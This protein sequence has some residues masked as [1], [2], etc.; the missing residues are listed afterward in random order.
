MTG[1]GQKLRVLVA[2]DSEHFRRAL[3]SALDG[4]CEICGEAANGAE[5]VE[6]V[7]AL[8]PDLVFLDVFMPQMRGGAAAIEIRRFSP[9]TLIV[10]VSI[11]D[12][13][14]VA[15]LVRTCGADGFVNKASGASAFRNMLAVMSHRS[16]A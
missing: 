2:D 14:S 13:P 7:R 11:E 8:A 4:Y 6:K 1:A 5:A 9:A 16:A 3:K 12:G 15:E 10:F